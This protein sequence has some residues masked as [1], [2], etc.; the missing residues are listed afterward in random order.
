MPKLSVIA[1]FQVH[2]TCTAH[3]TTSCHYRL[4]GNLSEGVKS[5]KKWFHRADSTSTAYFICLGELD[6]IF[7]S[8]LISIQ[9]RIQQSRMCTS[10]PVGEPKN[11]RVV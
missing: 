5:L 10:A 6:D 2:R 4:A 9:F 7:P 11:T 3:L 8:M 1:A